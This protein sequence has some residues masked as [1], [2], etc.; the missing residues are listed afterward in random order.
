MSWWDIF[1]VFMLALAIFRGYQTGLG[2]RLTGWVGVV[3]AASC[4]IFNLGAITGRLEGLVD[5]KAKAR[6]WLVDYFNARGPSSATGAEDFINTWLDR[7]Q[8]PDTFADQI[9]DAFQQA[10]GDVYQTVYGEIANILAAPLW[11]LMVFLT[12]TI[13][14]AALLVIGGWILHKL[15]RTWHVL[16]LID[17]FTGALV[18]GI[19][20]MVVIGAF[21]ALAL[22]I[23]PESTA[24]GGALHHSFMAPMLEDAINVIIRGGL[25]G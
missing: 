11:N 2:S 12:A 14:A 8:L 21:S 4:V 25:T 7:L 1:I 5:G 9:R 18:S 15:M 10:A 19:T 16:D 24:L 6:E 13:V 17:R 23:L 22:F 20:M 3:I